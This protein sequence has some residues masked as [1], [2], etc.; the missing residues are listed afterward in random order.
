MPIKPENRKLYPSNWKAISASIRDRAGNKCEECGLDNGV[1]GFRRK[2]GEFVKH[3]CELSGCL[4]ECLYDDE[5]P[6]FFTIVLTVA[7][8]NHDPSDCRPENLKAWCQKC[9]LSYDKE[10]HMKNSRETRDRKR[11]LQNLFP[12]PNPSAT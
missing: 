1:R 7:H 5:K 12:N 2:N 10:H 3:D 4:N 6:R 11:G 9:H 8:L